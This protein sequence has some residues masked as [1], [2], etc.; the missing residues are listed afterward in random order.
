MKKLNLKISDRAREWMLAVGGEFYVHAGEMKPPR[1]VKPLA[2]CRAGAPENGPDGW[3]ALSAGGVTVWVPLEEAFIND[4]V[5]IDLY[6]VG[7]AT[8]PVVLTMIFGSLCSGS[9]ESCGAGC[10]ATR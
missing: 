2:T 7:M 9:C 10:G 4:E 1:G 6:S 8:F 3:T 5:M